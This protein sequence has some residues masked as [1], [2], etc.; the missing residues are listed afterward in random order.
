MTAAELHKLALSRDATLR[1]NSTKYSLR[2]F[3]RWL[4]SQVVAGLLVKRGHR[5]FLSDEGWFVA[6]CLNDSTVFDGT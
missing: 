6:T 4:E 2:V 1:A 5:Y 3:R